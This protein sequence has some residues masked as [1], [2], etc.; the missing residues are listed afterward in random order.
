M[1]F[2]DWIIDIFVTI[3]IYKDSLTFTISLY[4]YEGRVVISHLHIVK[5]NLTYLKFSVL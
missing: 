3:Y 5:L 1:L 2:I 4:L